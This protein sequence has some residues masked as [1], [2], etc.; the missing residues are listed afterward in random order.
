M[1]FLLVSLSRGLTAQ[2]W[3]GDAPAK[4]DTIVTNDFERLDPVMI[5]GSMDEARKKE[6]QILKR[7]VIKTMPYAK[8]AAMKMKAMEDKLQTIQ[9]KKE[10][11]KY[12]KQCEASIKQ[13]YMDQL[14]NMTIGEGQVLMKLL[15]LSLIHI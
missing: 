1:A 5:S 8:M 4:V 14:K 9:G 11:K 13:M 15:H 3:G 2:I 10:R 7:R 6:Y 12:I